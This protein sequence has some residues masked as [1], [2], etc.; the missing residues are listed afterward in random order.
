[1][2]CISIVCQRSIHRM[3]FGFGEYFKRATQVRAFE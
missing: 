2:L 3:V 1:M